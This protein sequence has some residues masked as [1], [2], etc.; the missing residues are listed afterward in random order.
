MCTYPNQYYPYPYYTPWGS[1]SNYF[2]SSPVPSVS[3]TALQDIV[4]GQQ[5]AT[6]GLVSLLSQERV[7]NEQGTRDNKQQF[8]NL[9]TLSQNFLGFIPEVEQK[10][11]ALESQIH[12]KCSSA[13]NAEMED[14][15]NDMD[16]VITNLKRIAE[17][18]ACSTGLRLVPVRNTA[19]SSS[20]GTEFRP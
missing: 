19:S 15:L 13:N 5:R 20:L 2:D 12:D 7:S 6:N 1:Q 9:L 16:Q 17:G 4:E 14:R 11:A 8:S 18:F 3:T 10:F